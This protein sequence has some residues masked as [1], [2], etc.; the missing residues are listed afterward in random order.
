MAEIF[1]ITP[2]IILAIPSVILIGVAHEKY[3]ELINPRLKYEERNNELIFAD[4]EVIK[5][6][7]IF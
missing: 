4:L 7:N 2:I 5:T 1:L 3:E 6:R